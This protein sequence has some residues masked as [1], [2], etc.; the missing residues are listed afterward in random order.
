MDPLL[1]TTTEDGTG[2]TAIALALAQLADQRDLSVGYMK[3]KG[4]RLQSHLGKTMD[5]DP[6]FAAELL[7]LDEPIETLEPI[8]YSP[9]FIRGVLRGHDDIDALRNRVADACEDVAADHDILIIEGG[10]HLDAGAMLRLSDPELA[11]LIGARVVLATRYETPADIDRIIGG[12]RRFGDRL[13]GVLFNAVGDSVVDELEAD[14]TG[15]LESNDVSVLGAVPRRRE[16]AGI[17]VEQF[18]AD[19]G[20]EVLVDAGMDRLVERFLIGAMGRDAA[21]AHLRR[22][23][24]AAVITGGDRADI[25]SVAIE[26]PGVECLV[27]TGGHRPSEAILGR[28]ASAGMPVLL[29][30]T[31]TRTSVDRAESIVRSGRTRDAESVAI[32]RDL[33]VDHADVDTLLGTK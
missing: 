32:M 6:V 25:Q 20:A 22:T 15:F 29:V 17:P 33:L 3:P 4:T 12:A 10:G 24:S 9:T 1:L 8:V 2:K 21:A 7:G 13:A 26:A 11:D 27:L 23:R 31:D 16:L 14:V 19:L 18:A 5:R 30:T 28:A